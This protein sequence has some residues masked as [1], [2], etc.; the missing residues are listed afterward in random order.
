MCYPWWTLSCDWDQNDLHESTIWWPTEMNEW[1]YLHLI[2]I[3]GRKSTLCPLSNL[4]C[5]MKIGHSKLLH[6]KV[7]DHLEKSMNTLEKLPSRISLEPPNILHTTV[8][9]CEQSNQPLITHHLSSGKVICS[10]GDEPEKHQTWRIKL[11]ERGATD[12]LLLCF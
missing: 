7:K 11:T 5:N 8:P 1:R 9:K 2:V 6:R 4:L 3:W 12:S 10:T